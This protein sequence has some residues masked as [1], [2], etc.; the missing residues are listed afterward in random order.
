VKKFVK[1]KESVGEGSFRLPISDSDVYRF[2]LWAGRGSSDDNMEKIT[3]GSL[4]HYLFALKAWHT[5]HNAPY[6]YHTK[7]RVKLMLKAS[8]RVDAT[9]PQRPPKQP[10]LPSDL[11]HLVNALQGRGP[12]ADTVTDLAI[13]AFWGMAWMAEL[14]YHQATG[15]IQACTKP[16]RRD[17]LPHLDRAD[18]LL[19]GAKTAKPGEVQKLTLRPVHGT[20]CP[21]QALSHR[22]QDAT[23]A[24]DS[25][26]GFNTNAGRVNLTKQ[27][28]NQILKAVWRTTGRPHLIG[29]SFR[30]GRALIRWAL[31]ISINDI[32]TLGRWTSDCYQRYLR[33]IPPEDLKAS[34]TALGIPPPSF[35]PS[36]L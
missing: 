30:V 21:I 28:F 34:L 12:E 26:F 19:R 23:S 13:V 18:L 11:L 31:G 32:K 20:L 3:A 25:L 4:T 6:P 35:P 8:G 27:R 17:V 2:T 14:T 7:T 29:H 22:L 1:F 5:F 16:T 36:L 33:H 9:L 10:I 24:S 15:P